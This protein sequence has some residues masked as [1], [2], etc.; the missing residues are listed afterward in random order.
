MCYDLVTDKTR[1]FKSCS[2]GLE[3]EIGFSLAKTR[4][5][6]VIEN[7]SLQFESPI[8]QEVDCQKGLFVCHWHV[9]RLKRIHQVK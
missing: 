9:K 6:K 5:I 8:L 3:N 2:M 1:D 7:G 4:K